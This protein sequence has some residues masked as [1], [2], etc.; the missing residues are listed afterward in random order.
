MS[1]YFSKVMTACDNRCVYC[2]K[3]MLHD[4][5]TFMTAEEDHL[6]PLSKGGEDDAS[7]IVI[8]CSLCNRLK[9]NW[10]PENA[11]NMS[12]K[13]ILNAVRERIALRRLKHTRTYF[14]WVFTTNKEFGN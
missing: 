13:D 5:E 14:G 4:F 3:D 1:E 10:R 12:R 7:N 6:K 11:E 9:G 2:G 8:S